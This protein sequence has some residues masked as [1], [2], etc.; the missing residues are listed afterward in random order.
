MSSGARD[1]PAGERESGA[2]VD[3]VD[4]PGA[5][6]D[7]IA[8]YEAAGGQRDRY[9][10]QWIYDLIPAFT[11]SSVPADRR[12]TVR[13]VKTELTVFVTL[14]DDLAE[15]DGDARTFGAICERVLAPEAGGVAGHGLGRCNTAAASTAGVDAD[16]F[17]FAMDLWD[18]VDDHLRET[19]RHDEFR[20]VFEYDF[21]QVCNAMDYSRVLNDHPAM[22][23][24]T[25]LRRY[26]AHNMV[27]F[28]YVDVDLMH[29]PDFDRSDLGPTRAVLWDLQTMARIGNW[30]TTWR[31]EVR[32]G[33]LS[34]GVVVYALHHDLVSTEELEVGADG[35]CDALIDLLETYRVEECFEAEWRQLYQRVRQRDYEATS[36]D[37][38]ALVE[39]M[40]T[41]MSH[42]RDSEGR[43]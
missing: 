36:V 1:T 19:S 16:L 28:P 37:L 24:I 21:R 42:H 20:P 12:E 22:A 34:S 26:D 5:I 15:R 11:L 23:N 13:Q 43:K 6:L 17:G 33:D 25:G 14:L 39:S 18:R 38:E 41:V 2:T 32:E 29:S 10:W 9:V 40:E 27:A 4:L 35:D 31:R 7:V 3:D 8:D 30:L